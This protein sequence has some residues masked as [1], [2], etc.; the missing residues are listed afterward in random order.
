MLL[1]SKSPKQRKH[2]LSGVVMGSL[3]TMLVAAFLFAVPAGYSQA[4]QTGAQP[5]AT[6]S[7]QDYRL[8]V[9][10]AL[11]VLHATVTDQNSRPIADLT[12]GEFKVFENNV[13][14][15]IKVF[16]REDI[17]VSVGIIVD[18]SGSMRDKRR[19]VNAAALKFV[20]SSNEKDEVFIV[21]FSD[22]AY[23]DT[24]F[25]DNIPLLEEG[26]EKIDARGGTALYDALDLSLQHITESAS[27]DKRVLILITDGEDDASKLSLE[28]LVQSIQHSNVMIY[29]VG[30]LSGEGG[31]TTRRAKRALQEISKASGGAVFFPKDP[32]DVL[33]I[34]TT[35][36]NDIRNQYVIAYSPTNA[37]Q[38]GSF[39]KVEVR[40]VS[41]KRGKLNVRTRTGYYA[42]STPPAKPAA[43]PSSSGG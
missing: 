16:K 29:T 38:D 27:L 23:I 10:T 12:Q 17:P 8:S 32:D 15:Q 25:T 18:N 14:Q 22:D 34:A 13:E 42:Q 41:P 28:Q 40:V 35:I 7:S 21:N 1:R 19:G 2:L 26:L 37:A 6:N 33:S 3:W 20:H 43:T 39:R 5:P 31:G 30:L 4:Q 11:V 24:D 9:E 36:A